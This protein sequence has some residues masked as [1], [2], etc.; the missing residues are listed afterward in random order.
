M[1]PH[2]ARLVIRAVYRLLTSPKSFHKEELSKAS[3]YT[4]RFKKLPMQK[5]N[6]KIKNNFQA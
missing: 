6:I 4:T 1:K 2:K 3:L 5:L